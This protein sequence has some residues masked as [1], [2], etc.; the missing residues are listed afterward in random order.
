MDQQQFPATQTSQYKHDFAAAQNRWDEFWK[1]N[2]SR[3]ILCAILPRKG[4]KQVPKPAYASG[5]DGN[6]A[7][8]LD[9]LT[10][11][12]ETHE[13]LGE[14]MPFY[15]L[16]FA[17]DH[18]STLLGADL[19]FPGEG[20]GWPLHFVEDWA[21]TKLAFQRQGKWW[22]RTVD[23]AQAIKDRF[24]DHLLIASP[25]LVANIDALVAVRGAD[26]VLM[27]MLDNPEA[28]Q[29]ALQ[30]VLEAH[31]EILEEL[32]ALLDY[33][34]RG[35]INRHGLYSRGRINVP[36]CDTSCMLSQELFRQFVLPS[37]RTEM[38]RLDAVEYHLDGENALRHLED[39]CAIPELSVMQWVA[40]AGNENRDWT[41]LFDKID[42]LGKGQLLWS[43]FAG[44]QRIVKKYRSKKLVLQLMVQS[45]QEFDDLAGRLEQIWREKTARGEM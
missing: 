38:Q 23:F 7:P 42:A 17:A 8:V 14:A 41:W 40:G 33:P 16:E 32:S 45:Q 35:S 34:R 9:Q 44:S 36:Q 28:V 3:P 4:M 15:Y 12:A 2:N 24:G 31:Q 20:G 11:W 30:Q 29:R 6:F 22:R 13:F 21:Q 37:L 25:T 43:D 10:G 27:D 5:H 1:G 39:L 19:Q 18:F 26:N